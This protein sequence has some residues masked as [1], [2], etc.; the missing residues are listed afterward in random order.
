MSQAGA[1]EL[2]ARP[3]A[4]RRTVQKCENSVHGLG[5]VWIGR[6]A[7]GLGV[8]EAS[9]FRGTGGAC[10]P[11]RAA[12]DAETSQMGHLLARNTALERPCAACTRDACVRS[13]SAL[14]PREAHARYTPHT[15]T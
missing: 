9:C 4:S 3:C 10:R 14:A 1:A 12:P 13:S 2:G 11:D 6:T 8:R 15:T 7:R 5:A